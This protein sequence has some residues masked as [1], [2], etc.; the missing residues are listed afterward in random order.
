MK[1]YVLLCGPDG[2][3]MTATSRGEKSAGHLR[4]W[5]DDWR[6]YVAARNEGHNASSD[7]NTHYVGASAWEV[8]FVLSR[9]HPWIA[10]I[11]TIPKDILLYSNEDELADAL[12]YTK[13]AL[14]GESPLKAIKSARHEDCDCASCRPWTT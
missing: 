14:R 7:G 12:A 3:V 10:E 1:S 5:V 4:R 13:A 6:R 9:Q 11:S 2:H 8:R